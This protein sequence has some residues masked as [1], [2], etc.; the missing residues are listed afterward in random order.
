MDTNELRDLFAAI[1]MLGLLANGDYGLAEV[2]LRAYKLA[3]DMM[4]ERIIQE[5]GIASIKPRR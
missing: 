4:R 1:S 3:D 5:D 2:P